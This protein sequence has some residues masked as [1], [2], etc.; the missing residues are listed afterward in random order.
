M[1]MDN[2]RAFPSHGE[3][4]AP[5]ALFHFRPNTVSIASIRISEALQI[6]PKSPKP[7]I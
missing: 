7:Q 6:S 5:A 1:L 4:M 2:W 3:L